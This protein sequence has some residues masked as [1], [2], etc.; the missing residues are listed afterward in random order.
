M[1]GPIVPAPAVSSSGTTLIQFPS[2]QGGVDNTLRPFSA[3]VVFIVIGTV[4]LNVLPL[5]TPV[6][7]SW[8]HLARRTVLC[9]HKP[10]YIDPR[11]HRRA[12]H[13]CREIQQNLSQLLDF[14]SVLHRTFG[15][16]SRLDSK[17]YFLECRLLR[18][19]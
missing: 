1:N 10:L 17:Q 7:Y 2:H 12:R 3:N 6:D 8:T 4:E 18:T 5:R 19:C 15:L 9:A 13:R 11:L 14:A 16:I